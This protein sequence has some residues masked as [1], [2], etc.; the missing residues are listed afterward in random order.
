MLRSLVAV[1]AAAAVTGAV[2]MRS[3]DRSAGHKV[4]ELTRARAS[5][6]WK[7]EERVAE[8]ETDVEE[9]RELR[10]KLDAKLRVKRVELAALRTEHAALLR[11]YATAE[12]ERAGALEG[13]RQLVIG[14]GSS[15]R[16][17]PPAGST[18]TPSTYLRAVKALEDLSR[19]A[20]AQKAKRTVEEV[21]RRDEAEQSAREEAEPQGKQAAAGGSEQHNRPSTAVLPVRRPRAGA[22]A[23]VPYGPKRRAAQHHESGFD[24]FGTATGSG[25]GA[26]VQ[27]AIEAAQHED[28]ADVVGEEALAAQREKDSR[29]DAGT[30][31]GT[32]TGTDA[33]ADTGTDSDA[34]AD[35]DTDSRTGP[36]AETHAIGKVIDLTAHDETEHVDVVELRSAIS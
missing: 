27:K 30:E 31:A 19:N 21:R 6:E 4:A 8:L 35:A 33:V 25:V 16:A 34:D 3:W 11:R 20:A 10:L 12:T 36:R 14:A 24:F 2:L 26:S 15:A 7:N 9:S 1:T 17:L 29:T 22:A 18:P 23:I 28:L 13:R 5:D 32:D